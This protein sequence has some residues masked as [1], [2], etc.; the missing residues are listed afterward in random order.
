MWF[1]IRTFLLNLGLVSIYVSLDLPTMP[2]VIDLASI[3]DT[4]KAIPVEEIIKPAIPID[5][6]LQEAENLAVWCQKDLGRL[7]GIGI[8]KSQIEGLKIR[9]DILREA[10]ALWIEDWKAPKTRKQW[11]D[12][13][14]AAYAMQDELLQTFRYAFRDHR[15]LRQKVK[16]NPK[17]KTHTA[18]IQDLSDLSELGLDNIDLLTS[19]GFDTNKL[20]QAKVLSSKAAGTL[21][22][23]HSA[24]LK[25]NQSREFRDKAYTCLKQLVDEIRTGGRYLFRNK[26]ERLKGYRS[27]Y[28]RRKNLLSKHRKEDRE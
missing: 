19:I 1:V 11:E 10:Q 6:Y 23:L 25:G 7:A 16:S 13:A 3:S 27:E 5:T 20:N 4:I 9:S 21:A 15:T 2:H 22:E 14:R 18:L 17:R 26:P 8:T 28:L 12:T 24:N